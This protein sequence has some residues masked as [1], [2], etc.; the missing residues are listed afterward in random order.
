M[1]QNKT[2]QTIFNKTLTNIRYAVCAAVENDGPLMRSI[3][4]ALYSM[5]DELIENGI[6]ESR[7][8]GTKYGQ[9][10]KTI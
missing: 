7:E 5:S 6:I 3:V 2:Y 8:Q 9:T 10:R 1:E 4:K